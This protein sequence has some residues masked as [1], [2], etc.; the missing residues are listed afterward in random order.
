V[1]EVVA[2]DGGDG[3]GRLVFWWSLDGEPATRV[4]VA[5]EPLGP[6]TT[7]LQVVESRPLE[8]LDLVGIPLPGAGGSSHGPAMLV[9]LA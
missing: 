3:G 1:E 7:R 8:V 5:L 9:A 6:A 2:P 4:E